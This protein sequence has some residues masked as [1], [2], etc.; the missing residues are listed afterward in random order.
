MGNAPDFS[1]LPGQ[2]E[3]DMRK[4]AATHVVTEMK[5]WLGDDPALPVAPGYGEVPE[6]VAHNPGYKT[7][8]RLRHK[9]EGYFSLGPVNRRV[10]RISESAGLEQFSTASAISTRKS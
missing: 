9:T 5:M 6:D 3:M 4:L 2:R 10:A 1:L 7:Y 8:D